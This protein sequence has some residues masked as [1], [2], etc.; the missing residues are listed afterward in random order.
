MTDRKEI[1]RHK[2]LPGEMMRIWRI[3][4]PPFVTEGEGDF[5]V[6]LGERLEGQADDF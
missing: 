3:Y 6:F 5:S 4:D 2:L 1:M